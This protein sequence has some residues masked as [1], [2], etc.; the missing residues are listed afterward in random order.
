M[1]TVGKKKKSAQGPRRDPAHKP[2]DYST[3]YDA[4]TNADPN[5][6]YTAVDPNN[7]LHGATYF[8]S[9]GYRVEIYEEGGPRFK[10]YARPVVGQPVP[11][12][13]G[14]VL[15]SVDRETYDWIKENGPTGKTGQKLSDRREAQILNARKGGKDPF[16][17]L[18]GPELAS[19]AETGLDRKR[20][21]GETIA[22]ARME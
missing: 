22:R 3:S 9:L 15:M 18:A 5:R 6:K 12:P 17:G 10:R 20:T 2:V 16:R 14:T 4:I 8:E 1:P 21:S 13:F 7:N 11:G 19:Y